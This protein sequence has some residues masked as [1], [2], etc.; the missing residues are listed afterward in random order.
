MRQPL[1]QYADDQATEL[2]PSTANERY[3]TIHQT[4]SRCLTDY[5]ADNKGGYQGRQRAINL[6]QD[7]KKL[8][9]YTPENAKKLFTLIFALVNKTSSASLVNQVLVAFLGKNLKEQHRSG[10]Y[11]S[12]I[13]SETEIKIAIKK[14]RDYYFQLQEILKRSGSAYNPSYV[15]EDRKIFTQLIITL[16]GAPEELNK[17]LDEPQINDRLNPKVPSLFSTTCSFFLKATFIPS[18]LPTLQNQITNK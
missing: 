17:Q 1:P 13:F 4:F 8:T 7:T 11:A 15:I 3:E 10:S 14:E 5:Q 16:H 6:I 18:T 9:T 2:Q 12:S